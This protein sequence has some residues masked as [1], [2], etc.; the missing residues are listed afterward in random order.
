MDVPAGRWSR[1]STARCTTWPARRAPSPGRV[2]GAPV[3]PTARRPKVA[4]GSAAH[5][6]AQRRDP[7]PARAPRQRARGARRPAC[8]P[9]S[10]SG[11]RWSRWTPDDHLH[12]PADGPRLDRGAAG[13]ASR[14]LRRA[15]GAVGP[16]RAAPVTR[17]ALRAEGLTL[18]AGVVAPLAAW[19]CG[20]LPDR[21]RARLPRVDECQ[22][23]RPVRASACPP[24]PTPCAGSLAAGRGAEVEQLLAD[25]ALV[26]GRGACHH[27]DGATRLI[28]SAVSTFGDDLAAHAAGRPCG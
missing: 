17:A 14:W 2:I 18:G 1:S 27:P 22:A 23:V 4:P 8:S 16:A 20:V 7:G 10:V 13:S 21:W 25:A 24:C 6:G 28:A 26:E 9:F 11:R 19:A 12:R 15:L 5:A 3:L